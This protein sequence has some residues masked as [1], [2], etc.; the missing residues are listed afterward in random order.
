MVEVILDLSWCDSAQPQA[1]SHGS[2]AQ[3]HGSQTVQ[4]AVSKGSR[5]VTGYGL[6]GLFHL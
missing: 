1:K 6:Y 4:N 3:F 2:D 5:A